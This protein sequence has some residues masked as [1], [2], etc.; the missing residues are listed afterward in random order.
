MDDAACEL[1]F[2]TPPQ[3]RAAAETRV[4][5]GATGWSNVREI[6]PPS[7][8]PWH[9]ARKVR[10]ARALRDE[11]RSVAHLVVG[12]YE[13]QLA[14]HAANGLD[15]G[16]VVVLDDGASTRHV[17][18][19]RRAVHE[20]RRP[21]RL[22]AHVA[23]HRYEAQRLVARLLG[24]DLRDPDRV[25]YFTAYDVEPSAADRVV[26]NRYDWLRERFGRPTLTDDTLFLG[27]PLV[28]VGIVEDGLYLEMLRRLRAATDGTLW[29]RPHPREDPERI[30]TL[31]RDAGVHV[32]ALDTVVELALLRDGEV[33]RRVVA[34]HS[35]ALD[36]FRV[37]LGDAVTVQSVP[38]PAHLVARRWRAWITRAYAD[39]D[40]RL[41]EPVERLDL[42]GTGG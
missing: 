27:S 5:I 1:V 9:W 41:G 10:R 38:I 32:L 24:L 11:S 25:T 14:R 19:H 28:E 26:R 29:Y 8:S 23:R 34:N 35:T 17:N 40:A 42:L 31:V 21:P 2:L 22:H 15:G 16:E 12:N 13:T 4:A 36:T 7:T 18:A 30:A 39:L 20:G 33:P 37:I 3:A 6:G